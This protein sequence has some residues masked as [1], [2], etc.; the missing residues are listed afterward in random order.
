MSELFISISIVSHG[1]TE[2]VR[3]LL[4]S[5]L[6]VA[7]GD[8]RLEIV[9]TENL[10]SSMVDVESFEE[11]EINRLVN[12]RPKGLAANQNQA[13]RHANGDYFCILNPDVTLVEPV[14]EP[15]AAHIQRGRGDIVA[16]LVVDTQDSALDSFRD[17]PTP[18]E[19]LKRRLSRS[20]ML[21]PPEK[22]QE[23]VHP[24]WI[25]GTFLLMPRR[26]F[27][28]LGGM[29][30][31][32]FLYFEDVDFCSRARLAGLTLLVDTSVRIVHEPRRASKRNLV[33][34]AHHLKSAWHFFTSP[35]YKVVRR[36]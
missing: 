19:L 10:P 6:E 13:F 15:L 8:C 16:P 23:I 27:E 24:D 29:D 32:Y 22:L 1:Q 18:A 3:R 34:L 33:Y 36:L 11:L 28:D 7:H 17:L 21:L 26:V 12:P 4:R 20:S 25:A 5:L 30:E 9:L 35:V 31:G 2:L 14:F